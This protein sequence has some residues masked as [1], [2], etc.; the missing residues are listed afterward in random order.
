MDEMGDVA[1]VRRR[2]LFIEVGAGRVVK[3][4]LVSLHLRVLLL[5]DFSIR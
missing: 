3:W 1:C 5:V 2:P 4:I